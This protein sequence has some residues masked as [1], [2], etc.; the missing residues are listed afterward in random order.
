[1]E[2][3]DLIDLHHH[4]LATF[5]YMFFIASYLLFLYKKDHSK[6][7]LMFSIALYIGSISFLGLTFGFINTN[8]EI[9]SVPWHNLFFLSFLPLLY[10][11][12]F[13]VHEPFIKMKKEHI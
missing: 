8:H 9:T 2:E 11:I 5:I 10:V 12:F 1:M 6:R 3:I 4:W 13:A 7:K